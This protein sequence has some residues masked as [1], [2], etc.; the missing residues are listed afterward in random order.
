MCGRFALA[1][2]PEQLARQFELPLADVPTLKPRY[3]IAPTQPVAVVRV[4]PRATREREIGITQWGLV[5]EWA[6]DISIGSRMINARAET[7]AEKPSFRAAF[8]RRR[9]II[10]ALGFYEWRTT[11]DKKKQPYF[12]HP[13]ESATDT[14]ALFAF[15]GLW[16]IW[17]SEDGSE[18]QTCTIITTEANRIMSGLHHRMPVILP[19]EKYAGWLDPNVDDPRALRS[20]LKPYDSERMQYYPVDRKVNTPRND[21][22]GCIE[23][24]S[25]S[26]TLFAD[27]GAHE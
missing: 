9:C 6:K 14:P 27:S 17:F 18:V 7:L 15:A 4:G 2:S 19:P 11:A 1:A 10:P 8:K 24:I 13:R 22:A 5:P 20:F 25:E 3:N 12:I 16:E 26:P 21:D 23:P